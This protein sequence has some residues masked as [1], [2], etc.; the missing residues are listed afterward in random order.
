MLSDAVN[1]DNVKLAAAGLN[2]PYG[3]PRFLTLSRLTD[4]RSALSC[5]NAPYGA[6]CFLTAVDDSVGVRARVAS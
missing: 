5:L 4:L 1:G 2:A 3:A 6:P